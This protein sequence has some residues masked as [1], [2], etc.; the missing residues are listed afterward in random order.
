M[1]ASLPGEGNEGGSQVLS[2]WF[3]SLMAFWQWQ[4]GSSA[5]HQASTGPELSCQA[6]PLQ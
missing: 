4:G 6:S 3:H 1:L 2:P 5:P